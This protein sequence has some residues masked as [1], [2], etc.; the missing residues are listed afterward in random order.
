MLSGAEPC[1]FD[2]MGEAHRNI[3]PVPLHWVLR[4]DKASWGSGPGHP[5]ATVSRGGNAPLWMMHP[6]DGLDQV[7]LRPVGVLVPSRT[8]H[9]LL[10][11][12]FHRRLGVD[13]HGL[14]DVLCDRNSRLA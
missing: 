5:G 3:K 10:K 4:G 6:L 2:T 9:R 12:C 1:C 14:G 11:P 8:A 7:G 13:V